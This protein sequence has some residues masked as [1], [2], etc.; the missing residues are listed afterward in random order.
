MKPLFVLALAALAGAATAQVDI[1]F[2]NIS[3][4]AGDYKDC[5]TLWSPSGQ[6]P[7]TQE[8]TVRTATGSVRKQKFRLVGSTPYLYWID[9]ISDDIWRATDGNG[10][11][12]LDPFEFQQV[13]DYDAASEGQIDERAGTW[14]SVVGAGSGTARG[15]W[16]FTDGNADGDFKDAG[17]STQVVAGPTFSFGAYTGVSSDDARAVAVLPNGDAIWHED[18]CGIWF[19]TTPAGATSIFLVYKTPPTG[20]ISPVPA[21]NPDFGTALPAVPTSLDRVAVDPT[22]GTV[23]L[24]ANFATNERFALIAKDG[25]SDGDVNDAGEVRMFFDG[26]SSTP[27]WGPIDDIEWYVG[28]LYASYEIDVSLDPGCQFVKLTDLNNNGNAMDAGELT[29]IGRTASTDDPTSIGITVVPAGTF[30]ATCVNAD[31]RNSVGIVSTGA[32]SVT[33]SA[34]DVPTALRNDN[35]LC[36]MVMS[37]SGGAGLTVPFPPTYKC[38]M[39][40]TIDAFTVNT[41]GILVSPVVTTATVTVGTLPYPSGVPI[42]TKLFFTGF[43]WRATDLHLRGVAQTGLIEVRN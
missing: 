8:T 9:T 32:G 31:L 19:R 25:N 16:R 2:S 34:G 5:N 28:S 42:G 10:N 33:F 21:A 1:V 11:G 40:V 39:G 12:V 14:W 18:D 37:L 36:L 41:L 24:A 15:L 38:R 6:R 7:L 29:A 20:T 22:T 13:F 3:S 17:E 43:F 30:G 23:Y 26:R 27:A 35:T 4:T